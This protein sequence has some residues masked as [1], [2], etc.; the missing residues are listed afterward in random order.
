MFCLYNKLDENVIYSVSNI[1][2]L[3]IIFVFEIKQKTILLSCIYNFED[4]IVLTNC[5]VLY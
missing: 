3:T 4:V 2:S 1:N 5:L